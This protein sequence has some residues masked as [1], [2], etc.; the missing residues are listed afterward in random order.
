[1]VDNGTGIATEVQITDIWVNLDDNGMVDADEQLVASETATAGVASND[2]GTMTAIADG[3]G[4]EIDGGGGGTAG[5][6]G[7]NDFIT[8]VTEF[9]YNRIDITGIGDDANKDTFDILLGSVAVPTPYNIDFDVYAMSF[10]E[11]D[12]FSNIETLDVTLNFV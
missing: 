12:D 3:L 4:W 8:I 9:G 2:G 10:D 6:D 5:N 7:D 1:M 11:D